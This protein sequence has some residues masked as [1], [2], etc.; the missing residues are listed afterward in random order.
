VQKAATYTC[1]SCQRAYVPYIFGDHVCPHCGQE[2]PR[3]PTISQVSFSLAGM[4]LDAEMATDLLGLTPTASAS[5]FQSGRGYWELSL[6]SGRDGITSDNALTW[7]TDLLEPRR[8]AIHHLLHA[9]PQ[10]DGCITCFVMVDR[11][12]VVDVALPPVLLRRVAGLGLTLAF[13]V[14]VLQESPTARDN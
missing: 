1:A 2:A 6:V 12:D 3:F 13:N 4:D 11:D 9:A 7:L 5:S 8:R 14:C 10:T